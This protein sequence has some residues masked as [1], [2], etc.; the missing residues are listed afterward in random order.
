MKA[1]N[2]PS[3][4]ANNFF[5]A[6]LR[7]SGGQTNDVDSASSAALRDFFF[8]PFFS[9]TYSMLKYVLAPSQPKQ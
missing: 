4:V 8:S 7:F 9:P 6:Y 3:F 5:I 1:V 2:E